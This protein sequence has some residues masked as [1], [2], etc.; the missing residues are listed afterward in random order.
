MIDGSSTCNCLVQAVGGCGFLRY[1]PTNADRSFV[2]SLTFIL[3]FP[4]TLLSLDDFKKK[5]IPENFADSILELEI[6]LDNDSVDIQVVRDL[7]EMYMVCILISPSTALAHMI[8]LY[9]SFLSARSRV[10]RVNRR[11]EVHIL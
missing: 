4:A 1:V 11:L 6:L 3:Q 5:K 8:I 2:R 10:L 7:L 9:V